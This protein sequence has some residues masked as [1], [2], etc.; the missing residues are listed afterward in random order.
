MEIKFNF[1]VV[2]WFLIILVS[3]VM[4]VDR[5]ITFTKLTLEYERYIDE[6]SNVR[7]DYSCSS[8]WD[9]HFYSCNQ[10]FRNLSGHYCNNVLICENSYRVLK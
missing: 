9:N 5:Y 1:W 3:T 4:I 7:M 8:E 2:I 10:S 6:L